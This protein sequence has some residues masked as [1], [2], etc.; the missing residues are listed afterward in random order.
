MLPLENT[1]RPIRTLTND[2]LEHLLAHTANHVHHALFTLLA[3]TGLRVAEICQLKVCDL[4]I[5]NAP[6][7]TLEVRAEIAKNHK[8]RSIPLSPRA[9]LAIETLKYYHWASTIIPT[10]HYAFYG[11]NH[12]TPTS[13]RSIQRICERYGRSLLHMRLTPHTFRHTFATRLMRITNIRVVQ[14]L[15]GHSSLTATQIYTHPCTQDLQSAIHL[16]NP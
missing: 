8:P 9:I 12:Y 2:Q 10:E 16:L 14:D 5:A 7:S 11:P 6:V 3:D 1:H 13:P 4:W 15:L